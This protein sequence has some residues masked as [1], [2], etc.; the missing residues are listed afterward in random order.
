ML[1]PL[2]VDRQQELLSALRAC[3]AALT[4]HSE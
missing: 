1:A 2:D 4:E 3:I